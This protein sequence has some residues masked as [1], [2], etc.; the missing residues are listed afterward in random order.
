MFVGLVQYR[1]QRADGALGPVVD[2]LHKIK[3]S[4]STCMRAN[5]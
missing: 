5:G 3:E 1:A 4:I 2:P